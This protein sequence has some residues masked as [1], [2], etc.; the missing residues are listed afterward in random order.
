MEIGRAQKGFDGVVIVATRIKSHAE[1]D[2]QALRSG[3]ARGGL[4]EN[5]DSRAKSAMEKEFAAPVKEIAL[6]GIHVGGGFVFI[7]GGNKIRVFFF[8]FAKEVVQF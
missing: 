3:I 2:H 7:F 1:A 6:A 8:H 4:L 5:L